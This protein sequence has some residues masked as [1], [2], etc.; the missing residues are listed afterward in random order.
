M[1]IRPIE[2]VLMNEGFSEK[3]KKA[4][5]EIIQY[6]KACQQSSRETLKDI[7]NNKVEEVIK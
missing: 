6:A 4:F 3:E 5:M 7:V 2:T 1:K